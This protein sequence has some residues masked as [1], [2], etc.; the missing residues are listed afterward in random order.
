MATGLVVTGGDSHSEGCEF[1]TLHRILDGFFHI[2]FCSINCIYL[3]LFQKIENKHKKRPAMAP[4]KNK[5]FSC[6]RGIG[7]AYV[8]S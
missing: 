5:L 1:K 4:F 2:H 6:I 8:C 7:L 3:C